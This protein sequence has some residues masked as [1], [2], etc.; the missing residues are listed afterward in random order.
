M[1]TRIIDS[2]IVDSANNVLWL[3]SAG[4]AADDKPADVAGIMTVAGGSMHIETDTQKLYVYDE[5]SKTWGEM[6]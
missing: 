6:S 4:A 2:S 5:T 3:F 1:A